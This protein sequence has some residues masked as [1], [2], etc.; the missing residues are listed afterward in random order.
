MTKT[1]HSVTF[2]CWVLIAGSPACWAGY[3]GKRWTVASLPQPGVVWL[4]KQWIKCSRHMIACRD[5]VTQVLLE[6]HLMARSHTPRA[7]FAAGF[8]TG[9]AL[10][11]FCW[12]LSWHFSVVSYG[13]LG[14][15]PHAVWQGTGGLDGCQN[16]EPGECRGA[17]RVLT[18]G[19]KGQGEAFTHNEGMARSQSWANALDIWK[20]TIYVASQSQ[21]IKMGIKGAVVEK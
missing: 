5:L 20:Q 11:A 13:R 7:C 17:G 16:T 15:V 6:H 9:L 12:C 10:F 8:P 2:H 14:E 21:M 18:Q 3:T 1:N 4:R 19:E